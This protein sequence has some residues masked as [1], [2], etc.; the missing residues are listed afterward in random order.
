[1]TP[2]EA[3]EWLKATGS[4]FTAPLFHGTLPGKVG[5]ILRGGFLKPTT[6]STVNAK[7]YGEGTYLS[8]SDRYSLRYAGNDERGIIET[9]ISVQHP[10]N[11]RES[12]EIF[13]AVKARHPSPDD[14]P[15]AV[16]AE[17]EKR[18][19]DALRVQDYVKGLSGPEEPVVN[20]VVFD[21]RKIVAIQR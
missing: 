7:L 20:W 13:A 1:M 10:A 3:D 9:R 16:R 5:N 14:F 2:E 6:K 15:G 18:G 8:A 19:F 12:S 17:A 4:K 21:P 11:L